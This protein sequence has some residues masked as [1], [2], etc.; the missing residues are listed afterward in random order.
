MD[1]VEEKR[2]HLLI[3]LRR[4]LESPTPAEEAKGFLNDFIRFQT[5]I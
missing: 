4:K 2:S 3:I 1:E 5:L